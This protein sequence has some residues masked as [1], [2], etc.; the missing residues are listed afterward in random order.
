MEI[1][2]PY[3]VGAIILVLGVLYIR[4][5][6]EAA[7]SQAALGQLEEIKAERDGL[8]L[9]AETAKQC[10]VRL[11]AEKKALEEKYLQHQQD[12]DKMGV[13]FENLAN[14]I[15]EE[16]TT[17]FKKESEEG[18]GQMLAPLRERLQEFQKKV[19]ESFGEQAKE[20][21]S[22]KKEIERIVLA[23]EKITLQAE[24]LT[25]ALKG[26]SKTQG[27]WGEVILE[28]ILEDS[29]L[30][31]GVDYIAQG[32]QMELKS[33]DGGRQHPDITVMLPENKHIIIDSKVSLT[34]YEQFFSEADEQKRIV[35]LKQFLH[36]VRTHVNGL[37]KRRYQD[38]EKLGTP[39]F[40]LMFIPIEGAFMLALQ[41]DSTLHGYAWD[42]GVGI[43]C[44]STLFISLKTI[45]NLW[46]IET[47]NRHTLEI[48]R[49]GG[50]LYDK[51]V[52]FVE[53]MQKIGH[54]IDKTKDCYDGALNKLSVG[55]GNAL[56]LTENL[57]MLG[58]KATKKMPE[59]FLEDD[60]AEASSVSLLEKE[61]A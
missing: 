3:I 13:Q 9:E 59:Q 56:K 33:A 58:V 4:K 23:N 11:E 27:N 12:L 43:V 28:K 5:A 14:R 36:S 8:R 29:G 52:G 31:K 37:E 47:Q 54:H 55:K 46:R 26:E 38:S 20:Q 24:N 19:D 57:K 42:K 32:A 45:A 25:N 6:Q 34:H 30:R 50:K 1:Y 60:E 7:T 18:L 40:V 61:G 10:A 22:L 2:I 44:P 48:V 49:Q 16:K 41:Q 15:F 51:M 21:F 53:D 35:L 17:K 39:D